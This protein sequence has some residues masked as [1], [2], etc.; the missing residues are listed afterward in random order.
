MPPRLAA[1]ASA[2]LLSERET[3]LRLIRQE[4]PKPPGGQ[5][6]HSLTSLLGHKREKREA[7]A[8]AQTEITRED[9]RPTS[10]A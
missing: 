5:R 1:H 10:A 3:P 8:G 4:L 7:A 2:V 6:N 9:G